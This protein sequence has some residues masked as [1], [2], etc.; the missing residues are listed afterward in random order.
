[1]TEPEVFDPDR[2]LEEI[3]EAI[4]DWSVAAPAERERLAVQI[5]GLVERMDNWLTGGGPLPADWS[6]MRDILAGRSQS[7]NPL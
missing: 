3:R 2:A 5:V 1:M 4:A 7:R 6:R